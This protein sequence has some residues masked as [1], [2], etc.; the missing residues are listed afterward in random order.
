[1]LSVIDDVQNIQSENMVPGSPP[2][3]VTTPAFTTSTSKEYVSDI[4]KKPISSGSGDTQSTFM[5]PSK[6]AF[7]KSVDDSAPITVK[8]VTFFIYVTTFT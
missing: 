5:M 4:L 2:A 1:M 8:V 6:E 7:D 3:T